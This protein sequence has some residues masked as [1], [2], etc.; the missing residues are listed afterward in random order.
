MYISRIVIRGFRSFAI[1]DLRIKSGVT[2]VIGAN[3]TGKSNLL[4]ALRLVLD[5]NLPWQF[6][7]LIEHD[8]HS[9]LDLS[10]PAQVLI[11]VEFTDYQA[12]VNECALV[13]CCEVAENL[14]RL[15]FRF[16]PQ[17]SVRDQIAANARKPEGLTLDDYDWELTGGGEHD[18]STVLWN[19]DLGASLRVPDLQAFQVEYLPAL[20]DVQQS[21]RQSYTSPLGRLLATTDMSQTE[22]DEL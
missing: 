20:R 3:N 22:K 4:H 17:V 7:R 18:P 14:A 9:D 1:V 8:I 6:R 16:R 12:N 21:L 5:S 19:Q 11:S 2:C 15:H 13:G 10:R